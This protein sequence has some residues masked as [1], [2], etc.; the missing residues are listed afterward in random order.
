MQLQV[1]G[2]FQSISGSIRTPHASDHATRRDGSHG[3]RGATAHERRHALANRRARCGVAP[4]SLRA[5]SLSRLV[6]VVTAAA[7][8]ADDGDDDDDGGDVDSGVGYTRRQAIISTS[9]LLPRGC[10]LDDRRRIR[11]PKLRSLRQLLIASRQTPV[12]SAIADFV[13]SSSRVDSINTHSGHYP[14]I[15]LIH[16]ILIIYF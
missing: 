3:N 4:E 5:V 15:R 10:S 16:H 8:A 1:I 2:G 12:N 7:A 9:V 11:R 14:P 13:I 6:K